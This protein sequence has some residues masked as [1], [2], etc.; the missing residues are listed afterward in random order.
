MKKLFL[1][2]FLLNQ[3]TFG[4]TFDATVLENISVYGDVPKEGNLAL[5]G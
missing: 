3:F 1:S 2:L 4:H 5:K